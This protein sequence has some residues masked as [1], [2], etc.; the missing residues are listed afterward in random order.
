MSNTDWK[1]QIITEQLEASAR[2]KE[3]ILE[4]CMDDIVRASGLLADSFKN[5]GTL[6]I[7]GNGGSAADAQ[8]IA[9]EL[10]VRMGAERPGIR[11]IALTTDT[12]ILTATSNDYSFERV[13]A[14]QVEVMGNP[15]DALLAISTS[16]NSP[17]IIAAAK[18]AH[19]RGMK[20]V[21]YTGYSGG[22]LAKHGDVAIKIPSHDT[23][24]V[25][26]G[27]LTVGH[28]ICALVEQELFTHLRQ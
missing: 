3:A 15:G 1:K 20:V 2:I 16:G 25:Q 28:I 5:G 11:A 12:S 26:E 22:E 4:S 19:D 18:I 6:L 10:V 14:R 27:H 13:F 9:T 24:R 17:N 23:Q 21:V 7:C 8:H